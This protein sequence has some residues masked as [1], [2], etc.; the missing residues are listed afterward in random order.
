MPGTAPRHPRGWYDLM[1]TVVRCT[2]AL[3]SEWMRWAVTSDHGQMNRPYPC[4]QV[5][6]SPSVAAGGDHLPV[7][8]LTSV[9]FAMLPLSGLR[10][11]SPT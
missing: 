10:L 2:A 3:V 11:S 8:D 6:R 7:T 5:S 9:G 4:S 1:I